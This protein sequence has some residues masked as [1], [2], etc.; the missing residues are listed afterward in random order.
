MIFYLAFKQGE[1][2]TFSKPGLQPSQQVCTSKCFSP[3]GRACWKAVVQAVSSC[4]RKTK[5]QMSDLKHVRSCIWF[6]VDL[7]RSTCK[8]CQAQ[9]LRVS[10]CKYHLETATNGAFWWPDDSDSTAPPFFYYCT[11]KSPKRQVMQVAQTEKWNEM[12]TMSLKPSSLP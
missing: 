6:I 7:T 4:A 8:Y 10:V 9:N 11:W 12:A 2:Q 3:C 5:K 1:D